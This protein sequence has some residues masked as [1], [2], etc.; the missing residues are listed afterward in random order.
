MPLDDCDEE[1][2]SIQYVPGSHRWDLLPQGE[3]AGNMTDGQRDALENPVVV[4]ARRGEATFHHPLTV[5]GS[6]AN[7]SDRPRRVA[8]VN[9]VADGVKSDSDEPLLVHG[10]PL[11]NSRTSP[12]SG[13][14]A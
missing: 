11:N 12:G 9:F 14:L 4:K 10:S 1:N 2:G 6:Q 3:L 13:C 8:V 7:L 5:H